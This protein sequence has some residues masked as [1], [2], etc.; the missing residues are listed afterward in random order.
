METTFVQTLAAL[1]SAV[2]GSLL[3][4]GIGVSHRQL[5]ALISF[6]AGCL[7][8]ITFVHVLPDAWHKVPALL[9]LAS[10]GSGYLVFFLIS[11]YV[12]H[13]CPAC[14]AS[15]FE[16]QPTSKLRNVF[17]LI[18]VALSIHSAMD[19]LAI[20]LGKN[21]DEAHQHPIFFAISIHKLPEG[22]AL[23]ALLLKAGFKPF[24]AAL[25]TFAFE[26]T[27]VAGWLIGFFMLQRGLNTEW[28]DL[29]MLH[30]AGGFMFLALHAAINEAKDHSPR[31]VLS[32]F[33]LGFIFMA[34]VR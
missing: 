21:L 34:L 7:L 32:F 9:L 27:V 31:L 18:A 17:F 26:L 8:A 19:G 6:S 33:L 3:A 30:V 4:V 22:L 28:I 24:K 11:K 2:L 10:L 25:L 1:V 5:C 12:F 15:H 13:M 14:A 29:V 16:H 20:A 23:C